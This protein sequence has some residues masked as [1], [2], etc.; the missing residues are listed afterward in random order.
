M[1]NDFFT[2]S[3]ATYQF[4]SSREKGLA[5]LAKRLRF[6]N[7]KGLE[8][9][10]DYFAK[11]FSMPTRVSHEGLR[12]TLEIIAQRNPPSKID[13]NLSKYLD[14]SIVDELEREGFFKRLVGKN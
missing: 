6:K 11:S 3:D 13:M 7:P 4:M 8:E 10:Y 9:T 2:G 14:E 5:V 12:N 1:T